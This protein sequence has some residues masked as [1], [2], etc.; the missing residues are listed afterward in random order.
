MRV[1]ISGGGTG[2]HIFPA[3]AIA[4]KIMARWPNASIRFIG[5]QGR[6]EM[7]RVPDAGYEIDGLW[8]SGLQRKLTLKNITWPIKVV[9]SLL[10]ARKIIQEFE[11]DV[12]IGVGGY[13]SGPA[14][15]AAN[16]LGIPTLIQEQNS[17]P[18]ITNKLLAKSADRICVAYEEMQRWFDPSKTVYT[19]NPVRADLIDMATSAAVARECFGLDPQKPTVLL[20]GGSLGAKTLNTAMHNAYEQIAARPDVNIIWQVGKLYWEEYQQS[21][22]A[23]LLHVQ[24]LPFIKDMSMA[25]AAADVLACRAGALT[26]SELA[27]A[28]KPAILIPS[29]NVAEDHQTKNAMALVDKQAAILVKDNQAAQDLVQTIYHLVDDTDRQQQLIQAVKRFARPHATDHIVDEV[30]TIAGQGRSI[31]KLTTQLI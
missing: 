24:V 31:S 30:A 19:G 18:G 22:V 9:A 1:I 4:N 5:A 25:Y 29:P 3:I 20:T 7:Q 15:K 8:I 6:M 13:A 26:I 11:P 14:L 21:P 16:M 10:K 27:V 17:Y 12:V 28:A 23:D 2:G